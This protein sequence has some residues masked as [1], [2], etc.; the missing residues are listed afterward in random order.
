METS[1][2]KMEKLTSNVNADIEKAAMNVLYDIKEM[3][4]E[5]KY[6]D[7]GTMRSKYEF[8]GELDFSALCTIDAVSIGE[9]GV[10]DRKRF[11][12]LINKCM[13]TKSLRHYNKLLHFISTVM[14]K[15]EKRIRVIEPRHEMIQEK[16]KIWLDLRAKADAALT[17][18][19]SWKSDYYKNAL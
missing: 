1:V 11:K 7:N 17:E 3:V 19:K 9:L 8:R 12:R 6:N 13:A 2:I 10:R 4:D 15:S 5:T 14:L 18:Y 16:R